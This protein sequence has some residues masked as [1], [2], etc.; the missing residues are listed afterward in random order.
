MARRQDL[1]RRKG[2]RIHERRADSIRPGD[3]LWSD[4]SGRIFVLDVIE[5][6]VPASGNLLSAA[7]ADGA[8]WQDAD[9]WDPKVTAI[10]FLTRR[11]T[12]G[13]V[14]TLG[15]YAPRTMIKTVQRAD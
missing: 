1:V 14:Q 9:P 7:T 8:A 12:D 13:H 2:P 6:D 10:A 4:P 3:I 5:V 15:A 11:Q